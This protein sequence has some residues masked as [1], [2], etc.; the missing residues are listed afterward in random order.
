LI[1]LY[2][3]SLYDGCTH[4]TSIDSLIMNPINNHEYVH[5]SPELFT[6]PFNH[7]FIH[8]FIHLSIYSSIFASMHSFNN[9]SLVFTDE[10]QKWRLTCHW[11]IQRQ[12]TRVSRFDN[13]SHHLSLIYNSHH[14]SLIYTSHHLS[15]IYTSID[16]CMCILSIHLFIYLVVCITRK[17]LSSM[18]PSTCLSIFRYCISNNIFIDIHLSMHSSYWSMDYFIVVSFRYRGRSDMGS[19]WFDLYVTRYCIFIYAFLYVIFNTEDAY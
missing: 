10:H 13:H 14:L 18:Y 17:Y 7:Q 1:C 3:R 12:F 15:L 19:I 2:C 16:L 4:L 6:Y 11:N 8:L 9:L 5:R